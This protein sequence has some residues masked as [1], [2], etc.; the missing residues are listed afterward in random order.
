LTSFGN[1]CVS[2]AP[3]DHSTFGSQTV[4]EEDSDLN[5]IPPEL[6]EVLEGEGGS[7]V[8]DLYYGYQLECKA[9]KKFYVNAALNPMR[10]STQHREDALRRRAIE[11]LV[12]KLLDDDWIYHRFRQE[13]DEECDKFIWERF[14]KECFKCGKDL[15]S[16]SE[17]HLDHTMPL[18]ALWPLDEHATCLCSDC[19]SKKSDQFPV[20]FY[21]PEELRAL[22]EVTGQDLE[23]LKRRTINREAVRN[24]QRRIVW[25]FD[26]FLSAD[27]YQK[28]RDGKIVADLVVRAIQDRIDEAGMNLDLVNEYRQQTGRMP[29]TITSV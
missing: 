8:V 18:A 27:D 20:D 6:E 19:N 29:D 13:R 7:L 23:M 10:N 22:S 5:D 28:D 16:P 26:E 15:P 9:C 3:C 12:R 2:R 24:L 25:F 14:S 1:H 11:V 4:I 17:M 21:T